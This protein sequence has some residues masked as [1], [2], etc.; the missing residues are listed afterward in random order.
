M[1]DNGDELT[2]VD[3]NFAELRSESSALSRTNF[4]LKLIVYKFLKN[5]QTYVI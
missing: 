2:R 3:P 1:R 5:I 4:V